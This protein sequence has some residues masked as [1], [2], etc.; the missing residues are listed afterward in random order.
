MPDDKDND[1]KGGSFKNDVRISLIN[2]R[3]DGLQF[4]SS[5]STIT[6]MV[7]FNVAA[8]TLMVSGEYLPG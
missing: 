2:F 3:F 5:A 7:V 8:F 1:F 4:S 6:A